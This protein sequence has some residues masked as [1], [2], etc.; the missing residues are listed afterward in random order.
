MM[1]TGQAAILGDR[2][3]YAANDGTQGFLDDLV[4]GNQAIG[5][6]I[7]HLPWTSGLWSPVK[8]A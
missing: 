3:E 8:I 7:T 1:L 2:A 6:T 5:Q 4:I